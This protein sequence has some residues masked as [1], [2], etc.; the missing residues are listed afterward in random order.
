M[1]NMNNRDFL[2]YGAN[3]PNMRWPGGAGLAVSLVLNVEEGAELSL[4]DGDE[5]NE[6]VH[7]VTQPVSGAPDLCLASHF[8]YGTR[9]GYGRIASVV[10]EAG[11]P[12]TLNA[13]A[14][15]LIGVPWLARHA[16]AQG[17]EIC[18]HGWRWEAHA[19][20]DEAHERALIAR[21][22]AEITRVA[23][24]SPVG[25]HTK[26]SPSVNT[27]RL[28]VE[29]GGFLYDSDAYNDD[30]PYYLPV[31][32]RPHLVLPYAFDTNALYAGRTLPTTWSTLSTGCC[33]NQPTAPRCC[34]S[35]CICVSSVGLHASAVCRW[36]WR[37]CASQAANA[38]GLRDATPSRAIGCRKCLPV[39]PVGVFGR[40]ARPARPATPRLAWF[41]FNAPCG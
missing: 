25:W 38:C 35:A 30:L 21:A 18:S 5:R 31:A 29:H 33:A 32:G 22:H 6:S 10:A 34:P 37:T 1:N 17:H 20:M 14:R 26:S 23:G 2:G 41:R 39:D 9:V 4:A 28:L 27:R 15:S 16:V 3:P 36:R 13:C 40:R 11:V 8:E 19:G 7:E 24:V 12:M